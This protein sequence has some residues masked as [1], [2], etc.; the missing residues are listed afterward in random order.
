MNQGHGF[1][2]LIRKGVV[3]CEDHIHL[4]VCG[5]L[6]CLPCSYSV[7]DGD[8]KPDPLRVKLFHHSRVQP[9]AIVHPAWNGCFRIGTKTAEGT[10]QQGS[11]GHAVGVVITANG[12][13]LP[14]PARC[15]KARKRWGELGEV[16]VGSRRV[17]IAQE[18]LH[19]FCC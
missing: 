18:S 11:A 17:L 6:Q 15:L 14:R 8:Q 19:V 10:Q 12:Q 4:E 7:V 2:R 9:V 16:V 13:R 3:V 1:R 5:A